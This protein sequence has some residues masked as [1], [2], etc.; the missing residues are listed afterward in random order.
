MVAEMGMSTPGEL[1]QISRLGRPDVAVITNVRPVHL[2]F[3]DS[4]EAIAEAKK[5]RSTPHYCPADLF[6]LANIP[7]DFQQ[8][9][10]ADKAIHDCLLKAREY[11]LVG[12]GCGHG[13]WYYNGP[14]I[15]KAAEER[16]KNRKNRKK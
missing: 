12:K 1:G 4:E 8:R 5:G 11:G 7:M 16:K 6:R 10:N 15:K 14:E 3:F 13:G 9:W 2:E